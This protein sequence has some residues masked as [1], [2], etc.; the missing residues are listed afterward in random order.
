MIHKC[1]T[2]KPRCSELPGVTLPGYNYPALTLQS[3]VITARGEEETH[4]TVL[5]CGINGHCVQTSQLFIITVTRLAGPDIILV[6]YNVIYYILIRNKIH[7]FFRESI[8]II[9]FD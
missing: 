8:I 2:G 5:L 9:L 1:Q 4:V 3:P 6:L 7:E